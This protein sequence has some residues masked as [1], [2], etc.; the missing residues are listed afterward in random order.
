[1]KI[2]NKILARSSLW[3]RRAPPVFESLGSAAGGGQDGRGDAAGWG[4]PA[5][6]GGR[7]CPQGRE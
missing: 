7:L 1:M 4:G 5:A 2:N 6:L 3:C